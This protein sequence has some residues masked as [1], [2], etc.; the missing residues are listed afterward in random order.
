MSPLIVI[1]VMPKKSGLVSQLL[2]NLCPFIAFEDSIL[3]LV[4]PVLGPEAEL[5]GLVS[6]LSTVKAHR[7][8]AMRSTPIW[9]NILSLNWHATEPEDTS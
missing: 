5:F 7:A 6:P 8:L 4:Y 9:A 1:L 2:F 3:V